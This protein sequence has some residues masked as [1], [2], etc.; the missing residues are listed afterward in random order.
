MFFIKDLKDLEQGLTR[1]S[2]DIKDL[3]DQKRH[4][5]TMAIA[6]DRPPR[7]GHIETR[8]SL[9]PVLHRD[10]RFLLPEGIGPISVVREHPLPN[11]S[12]SGDPE[13]QR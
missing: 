10:S 4:L 8:R 13:L 2:I 3:K 7:Y 5:L 9:L 1:F 6:G 12:G 11:S